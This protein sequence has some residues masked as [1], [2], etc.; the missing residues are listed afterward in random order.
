MG[1]L[2]MPIIP[3]ILNMRRDKMRSLRTARRCILPIVT[4]MPYE[5]GPRHVVGMKGPAGAS[6]GKQTE[7]Y[8]PETVHRHPIFLYVPAT[9]CWNNWSGWSRLRLSRHRTAFLQ[10]A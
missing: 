9:G 1:L 5:D 10:G 7:K 3:I 4:V 8:F 6:T 2:P